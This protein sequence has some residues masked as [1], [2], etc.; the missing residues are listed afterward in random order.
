MG[1][2]AVTHNFNYTSTSP[3]E[4]IYVL[5]VDDTS[6]AVIGFEMS[7]N[8]DIPVIAHI[9]ERENAF[10]TYSD[11]IA[12]GRSSGLLEQGATRDLFKMSLGNIPEGKRRYRGDN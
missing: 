9:K 3:M 1:E 11:S 2:V 5:P 12:A 6:S 10:D 7:I 4:A 8:G